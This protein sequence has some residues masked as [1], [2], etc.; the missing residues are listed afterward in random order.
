MSFSSP[1][2][3]GM[4]ANFA[5]Q[6]AGLE[7]SGAAKKPTAPPPPPL[8]GDASGN[9]PSRQ[10]NRTTSLNPSTA[11]ANPRPRATYRPERGAPQQAYGQN[12]LLGQA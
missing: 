8:L 3:G 1:R 5:Q 4:I 2:S 9:R 6:G 10:S 12:T 11:N 7:A